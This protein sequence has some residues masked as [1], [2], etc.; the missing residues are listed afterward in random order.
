MAAALDIR[1]RWLLLVSVIGA[2]FY[3]FGSAL[4]PFIVAGLFAYL[5]NPL[6]VAGA[7]IAGVVRGSPA[8]RAGIKPGDILL[9][10]S[11][12]AVTDPQVMLDLIASLKPGEK[13]SFRLRRDREI[14]ELGLLIGKRPAQRSE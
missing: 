6:T 8:D 11:G 1:L 2:V 14:L 13:A 12:H 5:F 3:W 10:V 4:T 9:E 7:L